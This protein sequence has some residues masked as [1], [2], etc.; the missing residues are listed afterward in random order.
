MKHRDSKDAKKFGKINGSTSSMGNNRKKKN[1]QRLGGSGLSLEAFA[2]AKSM[3]NKYNPAFKKKQR[4]F[5]KNAKRVSKYKKS[6]KQ[7]NQQNDNSLAIRPVEDQAQTR[8]VDEKNIKNKKKKKKKPSMEELYMKKREEIEQA[9]IQKEAIIQAK[10]EERE[11][12]EA[13][14][15]AT[16]AKMFKKTK[17]GQPV[18]KYR[19]EHLLQTIQSSSKNSVN[20][21]N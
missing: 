5:Y 9:R 14:R 20:S 16:R 11:K 2:N 10:K 8:D 6:L 13:E 3:S 7:Q 4:E 12:A 17:Y 15:K 1:M 18:M 19:I 21:S